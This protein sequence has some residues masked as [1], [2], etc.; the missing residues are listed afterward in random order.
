MFNFQRSK[1]SDELFSS[2]HAE[3]SV[4]SFFGSTP[5]K[6]SIANLPFYLADQLTRG[7][8]SADNQVQAFQ[9]QVTKVFQSMVPDFKS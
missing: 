3:S 2:A 9:T 4:A 5:V 6:G 7:F 1:D 8:Q